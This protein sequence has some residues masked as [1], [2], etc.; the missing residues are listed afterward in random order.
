M[1]I[2]IQYK[3]HGVKGREIENHVGQWLDLEDQWH[4]L[5]QQQHLMIFCQYKATPKVCHEISL[6]SYLD[7]KKQLNIFGI[8]SPRFKT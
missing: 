8:I 5:W 7:N 1:K 3:S 6:V 2:G 4:V